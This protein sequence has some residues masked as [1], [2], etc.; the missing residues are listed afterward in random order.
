MPAAGE[1]RGSKDVAELFLGFSV[2][3][4]AQCRGGG[5]VESW[6]IGW[7]CLKYVPKA[8]VPTPSTGL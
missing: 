4:T 3:L 5:R 7:I 2:S 1:S 6:N 8:A